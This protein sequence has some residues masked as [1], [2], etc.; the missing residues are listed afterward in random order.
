MKEYLRLS[1]YLIPLWKSAVLGI[2]L[3]L[4]A[5]LFE[6]FS[7]GMLYPVMDFVFLRE[8]DPVSSQGVVTT[9][10]DGWES[11]QQLAAQTWKHRHQPDFLNSAQQEARSIWNDFAETHSKQDMLSFLCLVALMLVI[12]KSIVLYL[13]RVTFIHVE[14]R[15]LAAL[16]DDLYAHLQTFSL[17]FFNKQP[18]G[19]LISRIVN[20]IEMVR[21]F[22]VSSVARLIQHISKVIIYLS[23]ALFINLKLSL[24]V[25]LLMPPIFVAIGRLVDRIKRYSKRSQQRIADLTGVLQETF[26]SI[27]VVKAFAMEN[28]EIKRFAHKNNQYRSTFSRLLRIEATVSPIGEVLTTSVAIALLWYSGNMILS[29]TSPMSMG[30]FFVFLGAIFS[31]MSPIKAIGKTY[32]SMKRGVGAAER[33]I[34]LLDLEPTI[35]EKP[36]AIDIKT[37]T[38][39][40]Q[41]EAVWFAYEPDSPVLKDINF[42]VKHGEVLALVGPSG[43]GKST[44]VD[45]IPRFYDPTKGC[46]RI[47]GIDLRDLKLA[48]LRQLMGIVTQETI[49]F[50]D[51]VFNNIAY[52][53][54]DI[55]QEQVIAAAKAA[56]AHDFITKLPEGYHTVIGERGVFLSGGQR[57][58]L[59]IAR[60][61]LK[62]PPILI[63]DEATSALDSESE[64]LVQDAISRLMQNRTTI[65]IAHRLSTIQHADRI[66]VIESGQIREQGT[67]AELI[68]KGGLYKKLY[69][70]QFMTV[71]NEDSPAVT[72]ESRVN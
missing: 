47:D 64:Q 36:D 46:I 67:H 58:R 45:L 68:A 24:V 34:E 39:S 66:L 27:R 37:F 54:H 8:G 41:F 48:S 42:T 40:I 15:M 18:S 62:N 35:Q 30:Q 60:S 26:S 44:L 22:T 56:N 49:L 70:M 6:G 2:F 17:D 69:D 10:T 53:C 52:G 65:V 61:L 21:S 4:I 20:D 11:I 55:P 12:V 43:G 51:T 13:Q 63:F 9:A 25:F 32:G 19:E 72:G 38:D 50:N 29:T 14:Q 16:R 3:I 7:I 59:A 33:V 71:E 23:I 57:Q 5:S 31:M 1:R 28:Y